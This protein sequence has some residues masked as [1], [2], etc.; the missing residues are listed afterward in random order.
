MQGAA[1]QDA[2]LTGLH[3]V[4]QKVLGV[5]TDGLRTEVRHRL[6]KRLRINFEATKHCGH[7][8]ESRLNVTGR[9]QELQGEELLAASVA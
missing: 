9:G 3:A 8:A 5:G 1:A 4:I 7:G 6:R 2:R